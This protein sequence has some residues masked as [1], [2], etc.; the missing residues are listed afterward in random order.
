[1]C[2]ILVADDH[3]LFREAM[4]SAVDD[5]LRT[6]HPNL[7][8]IEAGSVEDVLQIADSAEEIDLVLLDLRMPGM[9]G[10]A[11]LMDLRRR[12]PALPVV[13]VSATE[14]WA[15]MQSA[16]AYG[17]SGYIPKSLSRREIGEAVLRVLDGDTFLPREETAFAAPAGPADVAQRIASLTAQ[18]LRVLRLMAAGKPNKI[19]AYELDIGET[20]VKAH[21]TAILRKLRVHSRTQ[22]VL[23][24]QGHL[25]DVAVSA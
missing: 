22:A 25:S 5:A 2:T 18:Q 3:P 19:I 15:T 20:T 23:L 7:R 17:A 6:M 14:D 21:I 10:F 8:M 4:Q 24:A 16:L 12:H 1:M 13:V 9:E 11:G